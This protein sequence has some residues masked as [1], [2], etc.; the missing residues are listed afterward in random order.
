MTFSVSAA[1]KNGARDRAER[2]KIVFSHIGRGV[3]IIQTLCGDCRILK[4]LPSNP[5]CLPEGV[6]RVS[7][8]SIGVLLDI[9]W[10]PIRNVEQTL[11]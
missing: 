8:P 4:D 10:H 6:S 5:Q 11:H 9:Q 7:I 1:L 3:Q 2:K